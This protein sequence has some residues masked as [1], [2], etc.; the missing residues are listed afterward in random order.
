MKM[1][2]DGRQGVDGDDL[3]TLKAFVRELVS[4]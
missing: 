3:M 1:F 4:H 2:R